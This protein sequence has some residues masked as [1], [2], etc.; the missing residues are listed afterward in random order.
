MK[1]YPMKKLGLA[2]LCY[3]FSIAI[4]FAQDAYFPTFEDEPV[5]TVSFLYMGL[6]TETMMPTEQTLINGQLWTKV[7]TNN[8]L[9]KGLYRQKG[10]KVYYRGLP[11]S[12]SQEYLMYDF[13]LEEGDSV[14]IGIPNSFPHELDSIQYHVYKTDTVW[15]GNTPR[16]RLFVGYSYFPPG[17]DFT[18]YAEYSTVWIV[19]IG[20]IYH[21]FPVGE[22]MSNAGACEAW[23]NVDCLR[24]SDGLIYSDGRETSCLYPVFNPNRIYVDKDAK[25]ILF[26]RIHNGQSWETAFAD[27]QDA[28][29]IAQAGDTIWVA[30]GTYRPTSD[31]NREISFKLKQGV[32]LLGG[33]E[34]HECFEWERKLDLHETILSG[35]IGQRNVV[36]DNSYHVLYTI[37]T[38]SS[39]LIDGFTIK[40]GYAIHENDGYFGPHVKGGGLLVDANDDFPTAEPRIQNC[41]FLQNV[42]R[43]GGAISFDGRERYF[44]NAQ[45]K[46]CYFYQNRGE[47]YGG[48]IYKNGITSREIA[49]HYL[50]CTFEENYSLLGGAGIY[51]LNTCNTYIFENCTFSRDT[52]VNG[53]AGIFMEAGCGKGGFIV[54]NC[55]FK[56]NASNSGGAIAFW[57]F[58]SFRSAHYNFEIEHSTFTKNSGRHYHGGAVSFYP[59]SDTLSIKIGNSTFSKNYTDGQGGAVFIANDLD[60][61][62]NL[63]INTCIFDHN[64]SDNRPGYGAVSIG[65]N[66]NNIKESNISINN[67]LFYENKGAFGLF[68]GSR[69]LS[70]A[71]VTN[72][73]FYKNGSYPFAKSWRQDFDST[74]YTAIDLIN[75]IIW[76]P[77]IA[78][79][80]LFHN[81]IDGSS[82]SQNL[83]EYTFKHCLIDRNICN[84]LETGACGDDM[85]FETLPFFIDP[86]NGDF[87]LAAC[88]PAINQGN[89][90]LVQNLLQD[91]DLNGDERIQD[92]IIDIG[93]YEQPAFNLQIESIVPA[94]CADTNDGSLAFSLNGTAP[95]KYI[96]QNELGELG[97]GINN[98][99]GGTF[100][101]SITDD[102]GCQDS[103]SITIPAPS[104]IQPSYDITPVSGVE[105]NNGKIEFTGIAGGVTPYSFLWNTGSAEPSL[106]NLIPGDYILTIT[107]GNDCM[108]QDTFTVSI[109][110]STGF[111]DKFEA[112]SIA[113][114]PVKLGNSIQL[115]HQGNVLQNVHGLLFDA[116]G[117]LMQA[118]KWEIDGQN[119]SYSLSSRKLL[120]GLYL[121]KLID[122]KG[123]MNFKKIVVQ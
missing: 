1:S 20:D 8:G 45:V 111:L 13:S 56:E 55:N 93:A 6:Q 22:C 71:K 35:D 31:D 73:T 113:P 4:S 69:G 85:L 59:A 58:S 118:F 14:Y 90:S 86:E 5:W 98:L 27:L 76:E 64:V 114:N 11:H 104:P 26:P 44:P 33:F 61:T 96:W 95:Y 89:N 108:F 34:G 12:H 17:G 97:N 115:L 82:Y 110:N 81:I 54:R 18:K 60:A 121:L 94:S 51:L 105:T 106:Y 120:P 25:R 29:A 57:Q 68:N 65:T 37:G 77:G 38:D 10:P 42:A 78:S 87:T 39:T 16:K 3:C 40:D 75:C 117:K 103:I 84:W 116:S 9:N 74:A 107:D 91:K 19:G 63:L 2:Y 52:V 88:S 70:K 47:A 43:F 7:K 15:I 79:Q 99:S 102:L 122:E 50:N 83:R 109:I 119:N 49:Q 66:H 46:D 62:I 72:S 80:N 24:T 32:V 23:F 41:R 53:S 92:D 101:I 112:I 28:I 123:Q 48:A 36:T 100:S 67:S 30:E 21:P